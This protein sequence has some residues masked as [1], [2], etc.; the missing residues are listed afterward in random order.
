MYFPKPLGT[1]E[2]ELWDEIEATIA[3]APSR[4]LNIGAGEGFYAAGLAVRC[5]NATVEAYEAGRTGPLRKLLK[6]NRLDS[7]VSIHGRCDVPDLIKAFATRSAKDQRTLV[8]MDIEGGE[9]ELLDPHEISELAN[10]IILVEVHNFI[11]ADLQKT[12]IDRFSASHAIKTHSPHARR[13]EDV[14][15]VLRTGMYDAGCHV[16]PLMDEG[17]V[18]GTDWLALWPQGIANG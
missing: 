6:L 15:E 2:K 10:C 17:R 8:V 12:L 18:I 11:R 3:A 4:I 7:R 13:L 5:P 16:V 14:P 9:F 1:Y